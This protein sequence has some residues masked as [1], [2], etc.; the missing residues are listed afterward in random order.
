MPVRVISK[1]YWGLVTGGNGHS[2]YEAG[3]SRNKK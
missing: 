2:T 3:S 1:K